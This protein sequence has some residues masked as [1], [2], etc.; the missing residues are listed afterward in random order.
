MIEEKMSKLDDMSRSID[1]IIHDVENLKTKIL[2]PKIDI[3]ESIKALHVFMDESRKRTA[4]LNAKREFLEKAIPPGFYRSNDEDIKMIGV[5][6]I[7]SLFSN[8][9]LDEKG[10]EDESTLVSRRSHNPE[11]EN[12][13]EK[14]TKSGFG[15]VKTLNS[16]VP[17]LFD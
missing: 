17:T 11:G 15:E 13:N 9:K 10:T 14:I 2:T 5:S 8:I 12:L 6:S 3:S 1:R 4:M 16:D 7:D